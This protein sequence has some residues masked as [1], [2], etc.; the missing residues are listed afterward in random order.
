MS[1]PETDPP[2]PPPHTHT[3]PNAASTATLNIIHRCLIKLVS[4]SEALHA[5][6]R[7]VPSQ[8]C[9]SYFCKERYRGSKSSKAKFFWNLTCIYITRTFSSLK[10]NYNLFLN[11][12]INCFPLNFTL[13]FPPKAQ[14]TVFC[15][16]WS[17]CVYARVCA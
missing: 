17:V 16:F 5:C 12:K 7:G 8:G 4:A 6:S 9:C 14:G 3:S 13:I 10:I 15:L 1:Q 2:S 11:N